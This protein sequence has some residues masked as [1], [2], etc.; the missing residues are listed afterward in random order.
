MRLLFSSKPGN[1]LIV[2]LGNP[3]SAYKGT[4]HNAGATAVMFLA[5]KIS[6]SF[7]LERSLEGFAAKGSYSGQP[8]LLFLPQTFMN[9][10]GEAVAKVLRKKNIAKD[11]ILVVHDEIAL[12]LGD[13]RLKHSGNSGGHN[14][15]ESVIE[16][17][18]TK[19]FA[20][21]RLGIGNCGDSCE[22]SDYVLSKFGKEEQAAVERMFEKAVEAIEVWVGCGITAAMNKFNRKNTNTDK[23]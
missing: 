4:R 15:L 11:D 22:L 1:K 23:N 21:L 16:H 17:L 5:E 20:R 8:L 12:S 13:L 9:L 3:G 7:K 14:G 2:G 18:G 19:D 10:S 6:A